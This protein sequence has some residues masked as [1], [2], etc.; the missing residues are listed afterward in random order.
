MTM[1]AE[2]VEAGIRLMGFVRDFM[3]EMGCTPNGFTVEGL[4]G[5]G[6]Q[7]R[8]WRIR[9][10]GGGFTCIA[11]ENEPTDFRA[12]QENL[13]YLRIG[14]HLLSK[15][16]PVPRIYRSHLEGGWFL[17]EDLGEETLQEVSKRA[18][19]MPHLERVLSVLLRMQIEGAEG[20][21]TSWTCQTAGYDLFVMRRYEAEYFIEAFLGKYLGMKSHWPELEAPFALIAGRAAEAP[22][23]FFLH[24][25]FQSRNIMISEGKIG[26]VDWQGGRLGPLAYDL[27]SLVID[28]YMDLSAE[29]R[30]WV[31]ETYVGILRSLHPSWVA[32]LRESFPYL[33]LQRN[34]QILGAFGFLS[35]VRGKAHF[36][37][38]IPKALESLHR[39]LND[40]GQRELDPLQDLTLTL[41][42]HPLLK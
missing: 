17:M 8:F 42:Q 25:D 29:Q 24:R 20:F 38:Y 11:V 37:T 35:K 32:P 3:V 40:L 13:S 2:T 7:R 22:C 33:A 23:H 19:P 39:S 28:P 21:D 9:E 31:F 34:L 14:C 36:Q 4:C 1:A 27:A 18:D 6:S 30:T 26:I 12:A 5:D 16:I 15:G 10:R 41:L